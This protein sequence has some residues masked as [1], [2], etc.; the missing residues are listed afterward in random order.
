MT[1]SRVAIP[2]PNYSSRG[3]T[4]VRLVVLHTAEGATTYQSLGNFFA[5]SSSGV[6]SQA[7]IDDTPNTIG[8]YVRRE[9]KSWTQASFNPM[10]DSAELCGFAAWTRADWVDHHSVML[11][12]TARW[13]AEECMH[14]GIPIR[15]LSAAQAQGG[16]PG[17]CQHIDLGAAG[18]G[19]VDCDYG[20]GNFPMDE[21]LDA[22]A[23]YAAG[24]S[25]VPVPEPVFGGAKVFIRQKD[26]TVYWFIA[27]GRK[28]YWRLVPKGLVQNI[29]EDWVMDDPNG[30][31]LALWDH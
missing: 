11:D 7:G 4:T 3:G 16:A 14:F 19:H 20:T 24:N 5:S 27:D 6:S 10:S 29:P 8:V 13:V 25:V 9:Q 1:L 21:V 18:G 30:D 2:S 26:G 31:W 17:V 12:N 28:S 22:A 23:R 15:R